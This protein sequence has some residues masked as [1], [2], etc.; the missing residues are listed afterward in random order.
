[1]LEGKDFAERMMP[2]LAAAGVFGDGEPTH[3]QIVLAFR[4]APLVQERVQL[5][6]EI[7]GMLGFLFVDEVEYSEDGLK[8]LPENAAEVLVASV[9]AL[10]DVPETEFTP[11][12]V[13][14][15]LKA[16]LVEGL[17]LKPRVAYGPLRVAVTGRRVSPPLFES[18]ELLGKAETMRRLDAL[19]QH[20]SN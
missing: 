1:M 7:P 14:D 11:D 10:E 12:A 6:G 20:L 18:M 3:E 4:A 16:A 2:Y 5:L 8:S 13:Q 15:A 19:V 9:G 17:E